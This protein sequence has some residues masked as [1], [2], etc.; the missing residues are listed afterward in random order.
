MNSNLVLIAIGLV[1]AVLVYMLVFHADAGKTADSGGSATLA[2]L[3]QG[4]PLPPPKHQYS[5]SGKRAIEV[6]GQ[7]YEG[8]GLIEHSRND[9]TYNTYTDDFTR[10]RS[11]GM[12]HAPM[13]FR[14]TDQTPADFGADNAIQYDLARQVHYF[15]KL[16]YHDY[17]MYHV[18]ENQHAI[19]EGMATLIG[20]PPRS[21]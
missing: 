3:N 8:Q 19:P 12:P 2:A 7:G 5:D 1:T 17:G 16:H 18:K 9:L 6:D 13:T 10:W 15:P 4:T 14:A 11:T 20:E 21:S